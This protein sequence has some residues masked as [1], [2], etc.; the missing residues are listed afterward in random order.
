M[1]CSTFDEKFSIACTTVVLQSAD[2]TPLLF[3][4]PCIFH[5]DLQNLTIIYRQVCDLSCCR[6]CK[7]QILFN[8]LEEEPSLSTSFSLK[9]GRKGFGQ[10]LS[11]R[12]QQCVSEMYAECL[13]EG[14]VKGIVMETR[15]VLI[16]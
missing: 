6:I 3:D 9:R 14:G 15:C 11:N 12:F 13:R 2:V 5:L 7:G 8:S 16:D 4:N 10:R 1:S